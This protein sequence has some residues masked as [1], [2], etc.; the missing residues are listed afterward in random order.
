MKAGAHLPEE[1]LRRRAAAVRPARRDED[2]HRPHHLA[3]RADPERAEAGGRQGACR[4][5]EAQRLSGSCPMIFTWNGTRVPVHHRRPRRRA[6]RR[7]RGRRH[8]LP[9]R[10]R[11]V[12]PDPRRARWRCTTATTRSASPRSCARSPISIRSSSSRV[13]HPADV[14]D[15]HERQVQGAAV[16]RVPAVRRHGRG[17]IRSRARDQAGRDVRATLRRATARYPDGFRR[18]ACGRR[19]AAHLELDFGNA[20]PDNRAVLVLNGWVDWADGSTFLGAAQEIRRA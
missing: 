10:S 1:D 17:S 18:D 9:G 13:D 12:R 5:K 8:V 19:R 4:Y 15:L 6:A 2:R 16:P 14:D 3:E 7:Q 11:R 20:A